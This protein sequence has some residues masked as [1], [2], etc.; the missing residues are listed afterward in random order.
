MERA[1]GKETVLKVITRGD[2]SRRY[3]G[4]LPDHGFFNSRNS[5]L[6]ELPLR[7]WGR[8]DWRSG[9]SPM[10]RLNTDR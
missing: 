7:A 2:E 5:E 6:P 8:S 1:A 9:A 10:Q 3:E 4:R